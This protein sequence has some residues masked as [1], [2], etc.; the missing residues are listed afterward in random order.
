MVLSVWTVLS[1]WLKITSRP[2]NLDLLMIIQWKAYGKVGSNVRTMSVRTM[3]GI[4]VP[5]RPFSLNIG[6]LF[7]IITRIDLSLT[8]VTV[9]RLTALV[10]LNDIFPG[11]KSGKI[12]SNFLSWSGK[13]VCFCGKKSV[14]VRKFDL[15]K[16]VWT[17][18]KFNPFRMKNLMKNEWKNERM[19]E[20]KISNF[21]WLF[22]LFLVN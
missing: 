14:K 6:K 12:I 11:D 8:I 17:L 22:A 9:H 13:M 4:K 2:L 15:P 10:F 18:N 16:Y 3:S 21:Q 5:S 19:K 1:V 7:S 20:W